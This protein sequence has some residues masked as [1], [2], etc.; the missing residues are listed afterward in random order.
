MVVIGSC[1][2]SFFGLNALSSQ[3][4]SEGMFTY[5]G[6]HHWHALLFVIVLVSTSWILKGARISFGQMNA[7]SGDSDHARTYYKALSHLCSPLL[8]TVRVAR[9]DATC[10]VKFEFQLQYLEHIYTKMSFG[11]YL[12]FEFSWAVCIFVCSIWQPY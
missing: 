4:S 10:L 11:V 12:T 1:R 2:G 6:F 9:Q 7:D 8:S 5:P 3:S